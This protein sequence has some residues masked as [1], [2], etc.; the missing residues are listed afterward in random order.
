VLTGAQ[1]FGHVL[2]E[3]A[4]EAAGRYL[5]ISPSRLHTPHLR[6]RTVPLAQHSTADT[7]Q[8][9]AL[10]VVATIQG[11]APYAPGY[12]QQL[13]DVCAVLLSSVGFVA[14]PI[15]EVYTFLE[16]AVSAGAL[17]AA[18]PQPVSLA[19]KVCRHNFRIVLRDPC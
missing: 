11:L 4:V 8:M 13:A 18:P 17:P 15:E 1:V 5:S 10:H 14:A 12:A 19:E 7:A 6:V 16:H 9:D 3:G 2:A